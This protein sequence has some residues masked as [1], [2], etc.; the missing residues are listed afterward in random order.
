[1]G[2]EQYGLSEAWL[3]A[4]ES[5]VRI[6]MPGRA[7]IDSLNAATSASILLFEAVRQRS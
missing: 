1:V 7:Q 4:A 3:D 5:R 6:P 2:A